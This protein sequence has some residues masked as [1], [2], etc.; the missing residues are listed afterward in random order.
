MRFVGTGYVIA[1]VSPR[2]R[3]DKGWSLTD[4]VSFTLM[5]ERAIT[6]ALSTDAHF[7][8]AGFEAVLLN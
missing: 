3:E 8:Q 2:D 4:C 7:I 5:H 1:L 6:A